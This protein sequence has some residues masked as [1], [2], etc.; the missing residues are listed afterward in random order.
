MFENEFNYELE[1]QN[2]EKVLVVIK[3]ISKR[4]VNLLA[5]VKN[6]ET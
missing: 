5:T 4:K 6:S 3:A 2:M 1:R